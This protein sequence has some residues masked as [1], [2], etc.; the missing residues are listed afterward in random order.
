MKKRKVPSA[1]APRLVGDYQRCMLF[2]HFDSRGGSMLVHRDTL[3]QAFNAYVDTFHPDPIKVDPSQ[4]MR[5]D[6]EWMAMEEDHVGIY[7]TLVFDVPLGGETE[8]DEKYEGQYY[9]GQ[10][11]AQFDSPRGFMDEV[12]L[13]TLVASVLGDE[14][15]PDW[16]IDEIRSALCLPANTKVRIERRD[17][18][19][20]AFG[21]RWI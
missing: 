8:M 19:E 16:P 3:F 9:I 4:Q 17:F 13:Q 12:P 10:V 2:S 1:P 7:R 5:R 21:L 6:L 15:V 18:G 11:Y 20:D 14:D